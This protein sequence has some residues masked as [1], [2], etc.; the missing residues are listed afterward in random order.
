[1]VINK[2]EEIAWSKT[3]IGGRY[4][5]MDNEAESACGLQTL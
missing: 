3:N 5:H 1:M 2:A 4:E